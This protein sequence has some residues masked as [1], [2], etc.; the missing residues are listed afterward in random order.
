MD[1]SP[2][3]GQ[4]V[5]SRIQAVDQFEL[6]IADVESFLDDWLQRLDQ[7]QA[8]SATPDAHLRKRIHDFELDKSQWE[9]KRK[10]ET[11]EIHEKAEELTKA[12]LRLEEE[13]RRF[14]QI[15][16]TRA[17]GNRATVVDGQ[18][19]EPAS[20][21]ETNSSH[22][23]SPARAP[24]PASAAAAA[25]ARGYG[26][27]YGY[28]YGRGIQHTSSQSIAGTTCRRFGRPPV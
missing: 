10:R 11:R 27:G 13:E 21:T 8:V 2:T 23:P 25:A 9:A 4:S 17:H 16:D 24:A 5:G 6:L 20:D 28:G 19:R 15:R 18:P 1:H 12:W 3:T 22:Q 7:L 26:Y 14:L